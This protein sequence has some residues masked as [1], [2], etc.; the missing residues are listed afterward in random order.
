MTISRDAVRRWERGGALPASQRLALAA[1]FVA[2]GVALS[3]VSIPVGPARVYPFQATIN[4][5]A[6]VLL[7]PWYAVLAAFAVSVLRNGLGTGTFLAF[8]GSLFGAF[9]VGA[10]YHWVR[11]TDWMA[12]LEPVGTALVGGVVGYLLIAPLEAPVKLLG[13]IA[14]NPASPQPYLGTFTGALA[15]VVSFA[16]SSVPG[17]ALGFVL[18]K[19]LRRAGVGL[20]PPEAAHQPP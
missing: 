5:L 17:A 12:F 9:L 7:G 6:G 4:V 14:A 13:F 16:V 20:A 18:L 19:A 15:L 3:F 8:P 1:V 11:R 10:G 2:L